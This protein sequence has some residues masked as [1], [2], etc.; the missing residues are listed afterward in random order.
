MQPQKVRTKGIS[1]TCTT[2]SPHKLPVGQSALSKAVEVRCGPL[3]FSPYH[4]S[5]RFRWSR[6]FLGHLKYHKLRILQLVGLKTTCCCC[7][8]HWSGIMKL[9]KVSFTSFLWN[10]FEREKLMQTWAFEVFPLE[11]ARFPLVVFTNKTWSLNYLSL[12]KPGKRKNSANSENRRNPE[13]QDFC[14]IWHP[15]Q[16]RTW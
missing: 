4:L 8:C 6:L 13:S 1:T 16:D 5:H 11:N 10:N 9:Q 3:W 2:S 7:R 12:N 14:R 15:W